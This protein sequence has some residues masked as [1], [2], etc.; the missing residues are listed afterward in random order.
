MSYPLGIYLP[1][2]T[3]WLRLVPI[4]KP[5]H[6]HFT[7]WEYGRE[8]MKC[9]SWATV[10]STVEAEQAETHAPEQRCSCFHKRTVL[11]NADPTVLEALSLD[12]LRNFLTF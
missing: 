9:L 1:A 7:I 8:R 10:G 12:T 2:L 4:A 6:M 3:P 5:P 11:I